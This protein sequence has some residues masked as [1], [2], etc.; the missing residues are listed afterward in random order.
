M[1]DYRKYQKN[2]GVKSG[3]MIAYMRQ[4]YKGFNK[5]TLCMVNNPKNYGVE[6]TKEAET[7]LAEKYGYKN[8]LRVRPKRTS[9]VKPQRSPL[10]ALR[11]DI[12]HYNS[13]KEKALERGCSS[14][15]EYIEVIEYT[16]KTEV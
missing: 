14:V 10:L 2:T 13:L 1:S 3:D 15:Q 6:L 4:Q 7:Y 12:E 5:S 16:L 9:K 11:K 8:S